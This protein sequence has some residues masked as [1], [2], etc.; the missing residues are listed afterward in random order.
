M[1][2][3]PIV[4]ALRRHKLTS[5][6]LMLQ[7]AFTCAIVCNAVFLIAQRT[8][9]LTVPS[10]L[11]E[12]TLSIV[13]VNDLDSGNNPLSF[14]RNDLAALRRLP[15][16]VSAALIT[17]LPFSHSEHGSGGCTSLA[18]VHA[19]MNAHSI[20]V[21]GCAAADVYAGTP[22]TLR[23][24]GLKVVAGRGFRTGDYVVGKLR[25]PVVAPAI[26]VTRAFAHRLFTVHPDQVIGRTLYFGVGLMK[27]IPSRI[28]GVVAH[29]HEA[30]A[31]GDHS[32][33]SSV[34]LPVK[35]DQARAMFALRSKP[36]DRARVMDEAVTILNKN[37]PGRHVSMENTQTYA[38]MRASYF[39]RDA[40]MI[41]L[42]LAAVLG[43]LFV[44]GL[45][46]SGL[47]S[48]WVA[49]RRRTIGI[50]RAV[51]ASRSSILRYFQIENFLIVGSGIIL[52][53]TGA[54]FLNLLLIEYYGVPHLPLAYL[55]VGAVLLWLLGQ[56]AVLTPALRASHVPP[57]VASRS[58]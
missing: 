17:N 7:V 49:Q 4:S 20:N 16:V 14:H 38:H 51:G 6:L 34:L 40:T 32:S 13:T 57:E 43:L 36:E 8:Q 39:R 27:G 33:D 5:F 15:G 23:T 22:G 1:Q 55:A 50:R 37:R 53:V 19:V 21:P 45:G 54:V 29:L 47:A 46:I 10:G 3:R 58:V 28:V 56:L 2:I 9:Q 42:L 44:T 24:L 12:D 26:I 25:G 35:P 52:G 18:A 41:R 30:N 11:D 48:F 31:S